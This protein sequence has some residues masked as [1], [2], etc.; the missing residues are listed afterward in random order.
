[1]RKH[2]DGRAKQRRSVAEAA[3]RVGASESATYSRERPAAEAGDE[4]DLTRLIRMIA[5]Q[6]AREAFSIFKD[7]IDGRT[8]EDLALPGRSNPEHAQEVLAGKERAPPQ[9]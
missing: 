8:V 2:K 9:P 7:A 1:M 4:D 6:A 3:K 5:R